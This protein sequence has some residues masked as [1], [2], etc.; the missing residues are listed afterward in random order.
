MADGD[1]SL[2]LLD[3]LETIEIRS[4]R[5][6]LERAH[7][8]EDWAVAGEVVFWSIRLSCPTDNFFWSNDIQ[9]SDVQNSGIRNSDV[10]NTTGPDIRGSQN[11]KSGSPDQHV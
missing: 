10:R 2:L 4:R 6:M 11:Y 3:F 1:H 8:F 5:V 9:N 7:A